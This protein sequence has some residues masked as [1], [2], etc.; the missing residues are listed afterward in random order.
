MMLRQF[1]IVPA[2][3]AMCW[4]SAASAE[5]QRQPECQLRIETAT[6][7]WIIRGFDP[8]GQTLPAATFEITFRNEGDRACVF[9]PNFVLDGESFGLSNSTAPR[10]P[11]TLLDISRDVNVTPLSG[12]SLQRG[13]RGQIAVPPRSQILNRFLLSV[14]DNS[15]V[16]DGLFSQNVQLEA[17]S[18]TDMVIGARQ[19]TLGL[20][21]LPSARMSLAGAFR[22]SNG[23]ALVDLGVLRD[24]PVTLPLQL[25]VQSTRGYKLD[26]ESRNQGKLRL[27][28][29]DWTV[30][31][32]LAI[33][34]QA[35][36][37]SQPYSYTAPRPS[38]SLD[39]L[40]LSFFVSGTEGK[41]AGVYTD[42]LTVS[43][44]AY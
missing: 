35:I 15:I 17:W 33:D 13:S 41:R 42:T 4:S 37:L 2:L 34:G 12:Q 1:L 19:L 44:A 31:Y 26:F 16:G 10:I 36:P 23:R 3:L 24:G 40:P 21:I 6:P 39:R 22:R 18:P 38:S 20:D 29:S 14:T 7:S 8:F 27:E 9:Q 11:Y 32:G 30:D 28:G 5:P 43:V 25:Q